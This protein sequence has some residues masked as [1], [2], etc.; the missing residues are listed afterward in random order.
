[1]NIQRKEQTEWRR[2]GSWLRAELRGDSDST[3]N[4]KG[5][6]RKGGL[7]GIQKTDLTSKGGRRR[8]IRRTNLGSVGKKQGRRS[9][10]CW[11]AGKKKWRGESE[12]RAARVLG[13]EGRGQLTFGGRRK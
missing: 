8:R 1:V 10:K 7:K 2:A 6:V 5:I 4:I 12:R 11:D 13:G 3:N 9:K